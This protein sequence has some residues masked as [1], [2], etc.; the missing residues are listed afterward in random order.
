MSEMA[1]VIVGGFIGSNNLEISIP[2]G[3]TFETLSCN[4]G[5]DIGFYLFLISTCII[6]FVTILD[7]RRFLKN[8][9]KSVAK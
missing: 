3:E 4:W 8:R 5:P 2:G 6:I 7:I 1:R 9:K